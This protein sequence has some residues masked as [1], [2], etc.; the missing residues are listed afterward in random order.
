MIFRFQF[1]SRGPNTHLDPQ[2]HGINSADLRQSSLATGHLSTSNHTK[3]NPDKN[4]F[5]SSFLTPAQPTFLSQHRSAP[6]PDAPPAHLS[7]SFLENARVDLDCI[8]TLWKPFT[9]PLDY[10]FR[11]SCCETQSVPRPIGSSVPS[12][13][14]TQPFVAR[15]TSRIVRTIVLTD[16]SISYQFSRPQKYHCSAT[17]ESCCLSLS[18]LP[19]RS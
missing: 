11:P 4:L 8:Y 9:F 7:F 15:E 5:T 10:R 16:R 12:R 17:A 1:N 6:Q 18:S 19:G 13:P 2:I 3:V 14:A